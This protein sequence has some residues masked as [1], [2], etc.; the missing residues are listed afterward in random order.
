M[1]LKRQKRVTNQTN[2]MTSTSITQGR[3]ETAVD[4]IQGS[5]WERR[6]LTCDPMK[7]KYTRRKNLMTDDASKVKTLIQE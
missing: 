7:K 2:K 4:G 1:L 6:Y 3:K 5:S